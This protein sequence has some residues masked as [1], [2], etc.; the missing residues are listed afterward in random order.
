M[1]L[2]WIT[3]FPLLLT[4]A[5]LRYCAIA[6]GSAEPL[7]PKTVLSQPAPREI[8]GSHHHQMGARWL[9]EI[10]ERSAARFPD[11]IALTVPEIGRVSQLRR[12][13]RQANHFASHLRHHLSG[14]NEV[15]AVH[16]RQDSADIVALHLAILKAGATQVFIDPD[17]PTHLYQQILADAAP[18]VLITET[19]LAAALTHP[20]PHGHDD[21]Y[22]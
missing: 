17:S 3:L 9:H 5:W 20:L 15:V 14:S 11:L 22:S 21:T 8:W 6:A 1:T 12:A 10:F 19:Q 16:L 4:A 7:P 18:T 13:R 2:L